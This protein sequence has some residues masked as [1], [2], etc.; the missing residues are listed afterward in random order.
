MS[1]AHLGKVF[2]IHGGGIDLVFPHHENEIA[3]SR[4]AHGTNVMARVW[5]HNGFLQVEGEKMSKSLG[6]FV[7]VHDLLTGWRGYA[8]PGEALRFNMLRT[9]YR[10]PLDWTFA[11]LDEA[12]KVLWDWY[13][14]AEESATAPEVPSA[15]VEA[16][17]DDL[18][19]PKAI[20]E[21]HKLHRAGHFEE[22]RAAL[23]FLGFSG[24]RAYVERVRQ[25][26]GGETADA[27][28]V[29]ALIAA[30]NAARSAKDFKEADRIRDE[31]QEMGV[32]LKDA[33]DP[34]T[35]ELVTTWEVAR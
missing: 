28:K 30:R 27:S 24:T 22:L 19:T 29:D 23:E 20:A 13:G 11:S 31:L 32:V 10:Q 34:K 2:D 5:M 35:G 25:D 12:H 18:N 17:S 16:M 9:H 21:M 33:K 4:C 1:A 6:N 7:T 15:I 8:W 3:Q 26:S 14:D